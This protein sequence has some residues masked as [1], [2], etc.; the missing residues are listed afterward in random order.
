MSKNND[1]EIIIYSKPE[2][3]LC[4]IAKTTIQKVRRSFNFRLKEIDI[5]T[6]DRLFEKY[7][8]EIPV[9][10]I[11]NKKAFKYKVDENTLVSKL[12]YLLK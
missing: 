6:D 7:K 11:N 3:H 2:C 10:F 9:V 5:L 4:D 1:I 8:E 12:K